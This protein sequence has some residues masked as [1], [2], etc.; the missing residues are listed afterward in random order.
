MQTI[1]VQGVQGGDLK[2]KSLSNAL[3][4]LAWKMADK[5]N[6]TEDFDI[7]KKVV[8]VNGIKSKKAKDY[9]KTIDKKECSPR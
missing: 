3:E 2:P 1:N 9:R 6:L 4:V 7:E 8:A 5:L